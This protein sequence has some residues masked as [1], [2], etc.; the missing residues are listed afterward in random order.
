MEKTIWKAIEGYE[1][2][3]EVSNTGLVKSLSR[4]KK[5]LGIIGTVLF[6]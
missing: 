6:V 5:G 3:Y 1:G 2:Y 4:E